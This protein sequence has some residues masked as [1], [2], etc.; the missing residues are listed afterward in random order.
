MKTLVDILKQ[1]LTQQAMLY[2]QYLPVAR[3][4][5]SAIIDHNIEKI[6]VC[7]SKKEYFLAE[8]QEFEDKRLFIMRDIRE[9]LNLKS[10]QAKLADL[11]RLLPA[12]EQSEVSAIH[13]RLRKVLY[14]VERMNRANNIMLREAL[15]NIHETF[16]QVMGKTVSK[17]EYNAV[18]IVREKIEVRRS[19]FNQMA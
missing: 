8:V 17:D 4:E 9:K 1:T 7:L 15:K 5:T 11:T 19:L 13:Q 2:E 14:E 10:S 3:E 18:G 16:E 12:E 6:T